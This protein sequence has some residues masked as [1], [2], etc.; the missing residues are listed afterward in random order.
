MNQHQE[1]LQYLY[2]TASDTVDFAS[3]DHQNRL[4]RLALQLAD[5]PPHL[6]HEMA[7]DSD[8]PIEFRIA[9]LLLDSQTAAHAITK[10]LKL[11]VVFAM[12][13]EHNRLHPRS[14][15]NPNG[16]DALCVKLDQLAWLFDRTQID[17]TLYAVD[18][19]CPHKSG[20]I[21][22]TVASSHQYGEHLQVAWLE[23]Y[24]PAFKGPLHQLKSA[25]DS[26]KGGAVI[27]GCELA[28]ED[29]VDA[30]I[31]TD[32]DNSVHLGQLGILLESFMDG[33]DVVLGNR[34]DPASVLVKQEARWG[35]GIK[36][37]RHMQRMVGHAIFDTGIRDTQAAFKLYS[38]SALENILEQPTV[39]DF[40]FDTD[41]LLACIAN[42]VSYTTRPF[43]FIDSAAES[44]SIVQGPMSTWYGL[45]KGLVKQVRAHN[46]SCNT[47]M[48]A[49]IDRQINDSADLEALID[50][51]PDQ[52]QQAT[53]KDL[54]NPALMS[55]AEIEDW[56]VRCKQYQQKQ[57][58]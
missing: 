42:E 48:C 2:S 50:Y 39:Y 40:S 34:K 14:D 16:E 36:L 56:I 49:V 12:W 18:D 45:L 25:D 9:S 57:A 55:P 41:W 8:A 37:L 53:D 26:R 38:R 54:G 47:E 46:L 44:A 11:G 29:G 30:V 13:G 21:A 10:P 7:A 24:L 4:Y 32:A 33:Y 22:A 51:L 43:A 5:S 1:F 31:Y 3:R 27:H 35:V 52:L 58:A 6:R 28:L 15:D 20:E 17:W 23:Q 19:G